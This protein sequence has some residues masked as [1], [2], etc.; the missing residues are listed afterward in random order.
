MQQSRKDFLKLSVLATGLFVLGR[1]P[2]SE[3][4]L[5]QTSPTPSPKT[6]TMAVL[7][8]V[9]KCNGCRACETTCRKWYKLP[10]EPEPTDLSPRSL[11]V[12][13]STQIE[14]NAGVNW[15]YSKWQCM[16]CVN[17]TCV[18]VCPTG[19]LYKTEEGPVL[20]DEARCIGCEYCVTAC[21]FHIPRFDWERERMVKKCTFCVDRI[22]NGLEPACVEICK[23]QALTF[24]ERQTIIAKAKEAEAKGAYV[25]GVN[26]VG[27]TS[28]IYVSDVPFDEL[29]FPAVGTESYPQHSLGI[30]LSQ[31]ATMGVGIPLIWGLSWCLR[32][33]AQQG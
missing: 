16:H 1:A 10:P 19:A 12:V 18:T 26:E 11:T 6:V 28:W 4:A 21:P 29:G 15:L 13:K 2:I 31:I 22:E 14:G 27:G 25:Y 20:Y 17:P 9:S 3:M 24:G 8:D 7:F 32:R 5:A 33:K 23:Q 30:W